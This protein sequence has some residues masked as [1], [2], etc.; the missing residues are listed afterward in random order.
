VNRAAQLR[1]QPR[2]RFRIKRSTPP[3]AR[4]RRGIPL[5]Q[6]EGGRKAIAARP[7]RLKSVAISSASNEIAH[8]AQDPLDPESIA[9]AALHYLERFDSSA[10]NLRR[11]LLR[12]IKKHARGEPVDQGRAAEIIDALLARYQASHLLDDKRYAR[13]LATSLRARGASRR[14]IISK[15]RV[16]GVSLAHAQAALE[17]VDT[18][19]VETQ[20]ADAELAAAIA[21]VRKRRMGPHRPEAEREAEQRRDLS[22]LARAGFSFD[23]AR[24]ALRAD[25]VD[26]AF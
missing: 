15:L 5:A 10:A 24:R 22:R 11:V 2:A 26:D 17:A 20:A 18:E 25:E 23:I 16:R 14:A 8:M 1:A 6:Y 3:S 13:A 19:A 7:R 21:L 9:R 12:R 4:A